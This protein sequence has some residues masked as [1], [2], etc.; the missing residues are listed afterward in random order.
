VLRDAPAL[1]FP[2]WSGMVPHRSKMTFEEAIR[3]NNEMISQF[4]RKA[5]STLLEAERRCDSEFIL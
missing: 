1:E 3:W 2:D 5:K 4:P